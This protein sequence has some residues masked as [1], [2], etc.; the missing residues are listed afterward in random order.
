M[1]EILPLKTSSHDVALRDLTLCRV[2]VI[3]FVLLFFLSV[4]EKQST[5]GRYILQLA[6]V[7]QTPL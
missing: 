4:L 6:S 1:W 5:A 2:P 7:N 3:E